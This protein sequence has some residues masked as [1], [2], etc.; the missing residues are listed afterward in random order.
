MQSLKSV[1][2][3]DSS[4]PSELLDDDE[5]LDEL[6]EDEDSEDDDVVVGAAVVVVDVG[7]AVVSESSLPRVRNSVTPTA[8][9]TTRAATPR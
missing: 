8:M 6:D 9:I 5:L 7:S 4:S 2:T 1:G 3:I